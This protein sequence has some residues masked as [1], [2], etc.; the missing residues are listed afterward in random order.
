MPV[1]SFRPCV[2]KDTLFDKLWLG[3]V[4]W[5]GLA[6][7]K[8]R[9]KLCVAVERWHY[10]FSFLYIFLII[11]SFTKSPNALSSSIFSNISWF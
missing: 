10:S 3:A 6:I 7:P 2:G 5:S 1:L 9:D 11:N 4:G 8:G